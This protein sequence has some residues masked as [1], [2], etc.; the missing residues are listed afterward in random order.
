MTSPRRRVLV[1]VGTDHH[2]F[3][4]LI[5][6]SDAWARLHD[7][8]EV[9]VQHGHSA[10]PEV[11]VG[12]AFLEH[13]ALTDLVA[14]SDAVVSHGGPATISEA[15]AAGHLP[16]V[17]PRDPA[18][19]E[20]VDD[21]Q[22]RF[23]AWLEAKGLVVRCTDEAAYS[24]ALDEALARGRS[25][26][27]VGDAALAVSVERFR[28]LVDEAAGGGRVRALDGPVVLYL[29]G[30]GRSGST[31]VER[32]LGLSDGVTCLGEV[33]HLWER[34][35]RDDDRC[36]CGEPFSRCPTWQAIGEL[37]F[38][39]WGSVDLDRVL[40]LRAQVDRQ[41]RIPITALPLTTAATRDALVEY[42]SYYT[43]IYQ[44]AA[45]LTGAPVV[46]DSS[47]HTSLA[48]ALSHDA[49]LDLRVLQV[50]RDPRAVAFSW[51]REVERPETELE[52]GDA[53]E[54]MP[55]YSSATSS[56][57]WLTS[58][59]FVEGLRL[60]GVPRTRIR[61]E[62]L[63]QDPQAALREAALALD[64]PVQPRVA[65]LDG[66]VTLDTSHSVAGNPMRFRTGPITLR[67]DDAWRSQMPAREQRIV[68]GLTAPLGRW[69]GRR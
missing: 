17:V 12:H 40:Q 19:G 47:K 44:A 18:H 2:P 25:D 36:A 23:S 37:A 14:T 61:Y 1:L 34:G 21:H 10:A 57:R 32:L 51:S 7:D 46:V 49:D 58:N 45:T 4:R 15:R 6:W 13:A 26:R 50:V 22:V 48:Y 24:A 56:R 31:L 63:V 3:D 62:D 59:L 11:C 20:H 38:G 65:V 33:V 9:V 41:R 53:V 68:G 35:L 27:P 55:R 30:F 16:V 28:R 54:L 39:G 5:G 66:R 42:S 67:V 29:A 8:V 64:L 69:Y 60:R 43:A 52:P